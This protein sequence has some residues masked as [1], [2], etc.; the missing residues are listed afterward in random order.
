MR[1]HWEYLVIITDTVDDYTEVMTTVLDR[2][3]DDGA[4]QYTKVCFALDFG[5]RPERYRAELVKKQ[6]I[7]S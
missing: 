3:D 4:L 5:H 2:D 7:V 6:K 1:T